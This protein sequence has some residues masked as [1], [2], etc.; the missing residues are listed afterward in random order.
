LLVANKL[1]P[2]DAEVKYGIG[3]AYQEMNQPKGAMAWL[4]DSVA[5]RP[6]ADAFNRLGRMYF[7][8]DQPDRAAGALTEAV[9]LG[10]KQELDAG[11]KVSWLTDSLYLLGRVQSDRR[12]VQAAKQ[13]WEDFLGRQPSNQTQVDEVK[14]YLATQ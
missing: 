10:K 2:D 13:A 6:S 8:A 3:V 1:R 12:N 9:K 14:R 5:T 11:T 4:A 7:D